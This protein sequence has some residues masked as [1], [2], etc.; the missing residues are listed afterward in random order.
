MGANRLAGA[1]WII[2]G[3]SS[4]AFLVFALDNLLLFALLAG[5]AIVG[6]WLG[7]LLI[8][9]P[10]PDAVR[11]SSLAGLAW[12]IAFGA[13][14]LTQLDQPIGALFSAIW[15]TAFGVAGAL[16]AYLRRAPAST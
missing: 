1:L 7:L 6:L 16:V 8:A 15:L 11:R 14:T 3:L 4:A 10:G 2:A 5:G 13:V 9:R 12:L